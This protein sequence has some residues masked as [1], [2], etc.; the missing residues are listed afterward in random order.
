MIIICC[1]CKKKIGEKPPLESDLITHTW[2]EKCGAEEM[3]KI[4]NYKKSIGYTAEL[5]ATT[6]IDLIK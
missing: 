4:R 2:C 6:K 5:L 3:E 1:V